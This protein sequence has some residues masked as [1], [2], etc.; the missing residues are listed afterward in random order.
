MTRTTTTIAQVRAEVAAAHA[1]GRRVALVP[2]MGALHQGH[3]ALVTRA[4]E[5]ADLVVV[6]IFVNPMQFGPKEDFARY[7]RDLDADLA[8][9]QAAGADVLFAPDALEVLPEGGTAIHVDA[10][11][12]GGT[13][14]GGVRPGHFDGVLTIVLKLL[15]IVG[16]DVVVFG[17]K[18]AQQVF[19]VQRMVR[20]LDVPVAVDVVDTVREED[21]LAL[22]SRNRYLDANGRRLARAVPAALDAAASRSDRDVDAM[23]AAAQGAI[24]GE[25]GA[26]LDYLAVVDPATFRPVDDGY[27][28]R[29]LVLVAA[30]V[31]G[32][33]LIDN[34]FVHLG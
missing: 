16:P 8:V 6:S 3:L 18:D 31:G 5:L 34:R 2:T 19:L 21:G 15:H 28:G 11:P 23:V 10:G 24:A 27:R 9:L 29:A 32:T 12:V 1:A 4:R 7:P 33:R 26:D 30:R 17:Q 25:D 22:S 20:D 13:L 14:E